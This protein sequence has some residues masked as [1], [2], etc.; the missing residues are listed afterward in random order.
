MARQFTEASSAIVYKDQAVIAGYPCTLACWY[1]VDTAPTVDN[2][3]TLVG[4]CDKDG[5][6]FNTTGSL[7]NIAVVG[8]TA[9]FPSNVICSALN[10]GGGYAEAKSTTYTPGTWQHAC[11]V[12]TSATSRACFLNGGN[13]GTSATNV[14]QS[15]LDRLCISGLKDASESDYF[16]G[17]IAEVAVWSAALTDTEVAALGAGAS[18]LGIRPVSLEFY[19]PLVRDVVDHFE[20]TALTAVAGTPVEHPA[21][22][23]PGYCSPSGARTPTVVVPPSAVRYD[24]IGRGVLRGVLR[25]H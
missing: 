3:E 18:P 24:A 7:F 5:D 12:F 13:K 22:I 17:R 25:G 16:D 4:L 14:T 21:I 15:A 10:A 11:G 23:Y 9:T 19:L 6:L 1:Y 8:P 20:S 2:Y